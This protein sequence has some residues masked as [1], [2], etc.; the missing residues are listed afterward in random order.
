MFRDLC[1]LVNSSPVLNPAVMFGPSSCFLAGC[2]ALL[3]P[4][5]IEVLIKASVSVYGPESG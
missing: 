2:H 5:R 4:R 1:L 3:V